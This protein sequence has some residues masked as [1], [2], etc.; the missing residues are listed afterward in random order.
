ME[1]VKFLC[2]HCGNPLEYYDTLDTSGG[3][4]DSYYMEHQIW[5]CESCQIDYII[6]QVAELTNRK[7]TYFEEA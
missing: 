4:E 3:L 7:I 2:K 5:T 1:E 6:D